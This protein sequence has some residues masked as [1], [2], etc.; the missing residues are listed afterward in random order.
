MGGTERQ[1]L[2]LAEY[3]AKE[4]CAKV[5]VFGM[6]RPGLAAARCDELGIPWRIVPFRWPCR[7]L[8]LLK[9]LPRF[10]WHLMKA[11]PDVVLAYTHWANVACGLTWRVT[12]ARTCIWNQRDLDEEGLT[13]C[14]IEKLASRLTSGFISNSVCAAHFLA[15][16]LGVSRERIH[17]VRNGVILNK[18]KAN[19][20]AWRAKLG[21]SKNCLL[22]C[23]VANLRYPKD[24][25][26][27]VRAWRHVVD[28]LDREG[29][30]PILLLAGCFQDKYDSIRALVD[31]LELDSHVHFLGQVKDIHGLLSEVD[32]AVFSSLSESSP[33]G[34][35]ESMASGLAVVGTDISGIRETVGQ[36]GKR[37]LAPP[38]DPSGLANRIVELLKDKELRS[39]A[40]KAN[41]CRIEKDFSFVNMFKRTVGFIIDQL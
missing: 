11:R 36:E 24:H 9:T 28:N 33:N 1:A 6:S 34:I 38:K 10:T 32:L 40:G 8:T 16:T 2:Y 18:S 27:L 26:T 12:G 17:V 39:K 30:S 35:L 41:F 25:V 23:M 14:K 7:K 21:V 20:T 15:K 22:A 4:Q 37:Y 13:G 3:L 31:D 19:R 5:Y 29:R